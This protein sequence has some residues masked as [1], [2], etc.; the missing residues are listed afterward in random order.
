MTVAVEVS[1]FSE[2]T[3][4]PPDPILGVSNSFGADTHEMKLN[5]GVGAYRTEDLQP[6]VLDAVKKQ[7]ILCWKG[8][9]T[10][11]IYQLKV[12]T[13]QGLSRTGSLRLA[14]VLIERYFPGNHQNI[15]N[16][17]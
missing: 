7:K 16:D 4:V 6:Y 15:F 9:K 13:V 3:M 14:A 12:A 10:K 1:W 5:L 8:E 2:L 17:A 11:S